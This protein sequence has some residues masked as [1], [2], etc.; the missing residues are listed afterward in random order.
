MHLV[1]GSR[2]LLFV[3]GVVGLIVAQ[4]APAGAVVRS[5][6]PN[7]PVG[8]TANVICIDAGACDA[9]TVSLI[10]NVDV[11]DGVGCEFDMGGRD[12]IV[13]KTMNVTG[14]GLLLDG[15]IKV[16]NADDITITTAGKLKARGD[17]V[18]PIQFILGGGTVELNGTGDFT[19]DGLIDVNGD[20]AG[21]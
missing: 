9:S 16:V 14:L 12:F 19:T 18:Q 7:D 2:G 1:P 21:R 5:C 6:D 15:F 11:T 4:V 17:F 10:E 8:N 3:I 13:T 20:S